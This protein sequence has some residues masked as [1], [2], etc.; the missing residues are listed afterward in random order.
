MAKRH[1][2]INW[3]T[4]QIILGVAFLIV[5]PFFLYF[6][7]D[8]LGYLTLKLESMG[9]ILANILFNILNIIVF[10]LKTICAIGYSF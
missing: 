3:G 10:V 8:F 4:I 6:S 7:M 5:L 2:K 1:K 9:G